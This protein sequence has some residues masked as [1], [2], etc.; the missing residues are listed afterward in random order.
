MYGYK[1]VKQPS[2]PIRIPTKQAGYSLGSGGCFII[3]TYNSFNF[4]LNIPAPKY[5]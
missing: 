4:V 5:K 2:F 1:N 3:I